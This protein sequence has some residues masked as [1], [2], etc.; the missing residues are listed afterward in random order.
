MFEE[1]TDE[2]AAPKQEAA[3]KPTLA[4]VLAEVPDVHEVLGHPERYEAWFKKAQEALH[5]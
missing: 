5:G 4:E 1:D 2:V 3:K